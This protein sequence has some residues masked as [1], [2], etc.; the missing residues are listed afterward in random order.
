MMSSSACCFN[1]L[2]IFWEYFGF[3]SQ[4]GNSLPI[5]AFACKHSTYPMTY[6][7][8]ES[9]VM[10]TLL[11]HRSIQHFIAFLAALLTSPLVSHIAF[12][13]K[14]IMSPAWNMNFSGFSLD[15]ITSEYL[16]ALMTEAFR[17]GTS[18]SQE[19]RLAG[20]VFT[21]FIFF[22]GFFLGVQSFSFFGELADGSCAEEVLTDSFALSPGTELRGHF[23]PQISWH[24]PSAEPQL[25]QELLVREQ[26]EH[27]VQKK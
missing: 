12:R 20:F 27:V 13:Y 8:C 21:F 14:N 23:E 6:S 11:S 24:S 1:A 10:E 7:I 25:E 4:P 22:W 17:F 9:P 3:D 2:L 19:L 26:A 16:K 5:S 18:S 15:T